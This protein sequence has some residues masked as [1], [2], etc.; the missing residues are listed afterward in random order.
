[1]KIVLNIC[2]WF[3]LALCVLIPIFGALGCDGLK[4]YAVDATTMLSGLCGLA[5]LYIAILLYDRYGVESKAKERTQKAIEE[6]ITEMQKVNFVLCFFSDSKTDGAYNDYIISLS[7]QS[8][9]ESVTE[10]FTPETLSST[11]FYKNSGMFGC[12]QLAENICSKVYLPK[13]IS[14]AVEKLSVFYYNTQTIAK[15]TRPITVL[16]ASSSNI[17]NLG[18]TLDGENT[19]IPEEQYSVIQFIDAY[20]G[21]K[22]AIIDWY[23][24]NN[25]DISE[26]NL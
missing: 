15:N 25:V 18:D 22:E 14:D 9:K 5:T 10:H 17:N 3:I 1:M 26:L 12:S 8:K 11:L 4:E 13:D 21:V 16:S 6:T 2:F 20:F 23:C 24:K 19:C 7:L